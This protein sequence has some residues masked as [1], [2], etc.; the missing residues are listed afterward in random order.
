M[1][2][3]IERNCSQACC[4]RI[5]GKRG[6]CT[7]S[8]MNHGIHIFPKRLSDTSTIFGQSEKP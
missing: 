6:S 5:E 8:A 3:V 4:K 7:N 1:A 2:G